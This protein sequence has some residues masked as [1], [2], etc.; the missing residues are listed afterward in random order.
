M[1]K[2]DVHPRSRKAEQLNKKAVHDSKKDKKKV[3][4]KS[5]MKPKLEKFSWFFKKIDF[6]KDKLSPE[7]VK[8]LIDEYMTSK[9]DEYEKEES[10]KGK[11][12]TSTELKRN[13]ENQQYTNGKF[14][15]PDLTD[16][17]TMELFKLWN[18]QSNI[19]E[20]LKMKNF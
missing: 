15:L 5:K 13:L 1:V 16:P 11:L 4:K 8:S 2:K 9:N 3:D 10:K 18:E 6:T 14:E 12:P 19:F 20:K 7:E 17:N